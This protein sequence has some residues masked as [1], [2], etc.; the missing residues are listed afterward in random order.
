MKTIE[1]TD[2][3]YDF[4]MELS[5]EINSQDHRCTRMPYFFQVQTTEAVSVG[6]GQGEEIW[7]QDGSILE[8]Q[9][10]IDEAVKELLDG[11]E[12]MPEDNY[13]KE[14]TLEEAGWCKVNRDYTEVYQEAFFTAKACK[15]H[16]AINKHNYREPVDF[17]SGSF[18]NPEL[19][20]VMKF[21]CELSGGELHK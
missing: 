12:P 21:L 14:L 16:I 15:E 4:L 3:M 8:T 11:T 5:K 17:L 6:E 20:L 18:R 1:I 9:E 10:E 13:E 2:Q 7:H 19:E